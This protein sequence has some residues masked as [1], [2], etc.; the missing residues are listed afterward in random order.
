[1]EAKIVKYIFG[2]YRLVKFYKY[3]KVIVV[4]IFILIITAVTLIL[5]LEDIVLAVAVSLLSLI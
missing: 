1:M 5:L 2:T 4:I 3:L